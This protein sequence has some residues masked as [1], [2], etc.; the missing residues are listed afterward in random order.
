MHG[1]KVPNSY[2]WQSPRARLQ[3]LGE[4]RVEDMPS[5]HLVSHSAAL[6]APASWDHHGS[7]QPGRGRLS[8]VLQAEGQ[9]WNGQN[10]HGAGSRCKC[11][12]RS[13]LDPGLLKLT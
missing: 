12:L 3:I 5:G 8:M 1:T 6:F 11:M 7:G 10:R 13:L 4:P 2:E 9:G